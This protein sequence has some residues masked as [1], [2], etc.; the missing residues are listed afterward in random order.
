MVCHFQD[1]GSGVYRSSFA[2]QVHPPSLQDDTSLL[3]LLS[4]LCRGDNIDSKASV[5]SSGFQR[6][7]VVLHM[8]NQAQTVGPEAILGPCGPSYQWPYLI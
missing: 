3:L 8:M 1:D 5:I 6:P 4:P 7:E 2:E